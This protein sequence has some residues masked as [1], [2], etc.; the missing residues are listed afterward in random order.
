[1]AFGFSCRGEGYCRLQRGNLQS[2]RGTPR[3]VWMVSVTLEVFAIHC[4]AF[5]PTTRYHLVLNLEPS[6]AITQNFIPRKRVGAVLEFL[7]DQK[8]SIS[9]FSDD[10]EDPYQLF[11]E[12]LR[13]AD[14]KLLEEGLLEL[15]KLA[16]PGKNRGKWEELKEDT[17]AGGFSFGFGG[18]DDSEHGS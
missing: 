17:E 1:M 13:E 5:D 15:E 10:I 11:V 18:D 9:G 3:S 2:R 6:I 12:R 16:L 4:T 8:Q 14:P 7:R